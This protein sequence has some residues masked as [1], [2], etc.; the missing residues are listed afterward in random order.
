MTDG[1]V[2]W[3]NAGQEQIFTAGPRPICASGGYGSSKTFGCCLKALYLSDRYPKNR[4]VIFRRIGDELRKTTMATFYK[5]C[6]PSAYSGEEGR[7]SDHEK[8]LRLNN[9]SEILF[10]HMEDPQFETVLRGLEINWFFGDQ[11]EEIEEETFDH[12]MARLGRWDQA[13]VPLDEVEQYVRDHHQAWPWV[14]PTSRKPIPPTY[15]MIACNPDTELHWIY[16]R[17]HPDSPEWKDTYRAQGYRMIMCSTLDNIY[18]PQQNKTQL[19]DHDE[20]FIRRY[21]RGEWGLP[22][23]QIHTIAPESMITFSDAHD[24]QTFL[25][26]LRHTCTLHRTLDHGDTAPTCCGWFAVDRDSNVYAYREY[27]QPNKLV[28][29]HRQ[30]IHDLSMGETYQSNLADP[31]IFALASQKHGGRWSTSAEYSDRTHM[32]PATAIQWLPADNN[33]LGTRNRINEY[34]RV[35]P[36]RIHPVTKQRGAPRLYFVMRTA[37]YPQGVDHIPRQTRSQKRVQIGTEGG[38]PLFTDERDP[39]ITDHGADVLR[40]FMASRA[41]V[42]QEPSTRPSAKSFFG[43]RQLLAKKQARAMRTRRA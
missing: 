24:A 12:L 41:P 1:V 7:R 30:A 5:I 21:V 18:L 25:E 13:V 43:K 27:Y 6:P 9:G 19:L 16:R 31:S 36:Q 38:K 22:E 8:L 15:P 32:D 2:G 3:A 4:G 17:F 14:H 11:A 39:K 35:D 20:A 10:M 23:G 29:D 42:S 34:L 28:S 37:A 26:H 33:E 40:Y